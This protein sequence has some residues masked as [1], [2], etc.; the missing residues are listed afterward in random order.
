MRTKNIKNIIK[1]ILIVCCLQFLIFGCKK[2]NEEQV[3][4][5]SV[6]SQINYKVNYR[7]DAIIITRMKGENSKPLSALNLCLKQKE[8]YLTRYG[9]DILLLTN[10]HKIDTIYEHLTARPYNVEVRYIGGKLYSSSM[11]MLVGC[12]DN[13]ENYRKNLIIRIFYDDKYKI[14]KIQESELLIEYQPQ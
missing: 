5:P 3:F 14:K 10:K 11:Y 2:T 13:Y 7:K 8:Y 1:G 12:G 4:T 6:D 9:K